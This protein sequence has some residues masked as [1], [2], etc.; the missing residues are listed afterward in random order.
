MDCGI[1]IPPTDG[2]I[3]SYSGTK[4][5]NIVTFKCDE[6][7]RPSAEVNGTCG[8]DARWNPAP[9]R[10]NCTFVEGKMTLYGFK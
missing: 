9:N 3:V 1:P 2:T 10:H 5:G 7:F 8:S 4:L 6:G